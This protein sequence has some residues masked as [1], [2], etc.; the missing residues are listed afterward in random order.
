MTYL[1]LLDP[2]IASGAS[3][4]MLITSMPTAQTVGMTFALPLGLAW[5]GS[6]RLLG[7]KIAQHP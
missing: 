1:D 5:N 6:D 2:A 7:G 4:S 3:A